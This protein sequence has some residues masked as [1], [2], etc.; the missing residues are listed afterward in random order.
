MWSQNFD[1]KKYTRKQDSLNKNDYEFLKQELEKTRYYSKC[2]HGTTYIPINRLND[3]FDI[4]NHTNEDSYFV[5]HS[6]SQYSPPVV[7]FPYDISIDNS[8][9]ESYKKY[10]AEYGHTL[11]NLFTPDKIINESV[12]N[13]VYVDLATTDVIPGGIT[14][15]KINLIID[16]IKAKEGHRILVKSQKTYITLNNSIDPETYFNG[17]YYINKSDVLNT[18]YY[19]YNSENGIYIFLNKRLIRETDLNNYEDCI[20]Y[21]IGCKLGIANADKQYHLARLANG[22]YPLYN[23]NDN[24]EFIEKHNWLLRNR[25]DYNNVLDIDYNDILKLPAHTIMILGYTYSIPERTIAIGEFG[26]IINTQGG[27]PNIINN[28]HKVKLNSITSTSN[29]YWICGD[30]GTMLK[31]EKLSFNIE[32][33]ELNTYNNLNSVSFFNN[34]RGFV[35]GDF[36]TLYETIDG[37]IS[38]KAIEVEE[39]INF[40]YNKVLYYKFNKVYVGGDNG[41]FLELEYLNSEWSIYKRTIRKI[42]DDDDDFELIFDINDITTISTNSWNIAYTGTSST[43]S[44]NKEALLI[45]T[46]NDNIIIHDINNFSIHDFIYL[47]YIQPVG[48]IKSII[49]TGTSSNQ[50]YFNSEN[51]IYTFDINEF[52]FVD[53]VS[54]ISKIGITNGTP[55]YNTVFTPAI[56][57]TNKIYNYSNI[58][59]EITGNKSLLLSSTYSTAIT[60]PI[61]TTSFSDSLKSKLLFLDYEI[62]S[63]L[64]FFDDQQNYRLPNTL[65]LSFVD[66]IT[67]TNVTSIEI[68]NQPNEYNWLSYQKDALKTIRYHSV[69]AVSQVNQSSI[70]E[71]STKFRISSISNSISLT[72][73]SLT[74][75]KDIVKHLAPTIDTYGISNF[76]NTGNTLNVVGIPYTIYAYNDIIIISSNNIIALEGD[77]LMIESDVIKSFFIINRVEVISGKNYYYCYSKYD[78]AILNDLKDSSGPIIITNLNTFN[79][80]QTFIDRFNEHPISVGYSVDIDNGKTILST[81]FNNFTAYYNMSSDVEINSVI[82]PMNYEK[83]FLDFGFKPTYNLLGYLSHIDP[84]VFSSSKEFKVMP[85]YYG[86]PFSNTQPTFNG[87]YFDTN[88]GTNKLFFSLS[89]KTE[90]DLLFDNTFID[91]NLNYSSSVVSTEKLLITKKYYDK[92]N[93]WYVIEFH[94]KLK[95]NVGTT[96]ASFDVISR[97]RL[98]QISQDLEELNNIQRG[99]SQTDYNIKFGQNDTSNIPNVWSFSNLEG[100]LNSK[101]NTNSYALIFTADHDIKELITGIVYIDSKNQLALNTIKLSREVNSDIVELMMHTNN[102][103][104]LIRTATEHKLNV[105]DGFVL[106][107]KDITNTSYY[108]NPQYNGYLTVN[109]WISDTIFVANI[110]FGSFTIGDVGS[111][112]HV[113][114]DPFFNYQPVDIIDVGIDKKS[115][116]SV[117]ILPK[118]IKLEGSKYNLINLDLNKFKF[119]LVD[120]LNLDLITKNYSWLLEAEIDNAIIGEDENGLVWY[121]GIWYCGRWFGGTWYSGEW[122]SGDWYGGIWDSTKVENKILSVNVD[123]IIKDNSYSVWKSGKW[124]DGEWR[125]G[126]W[127]NGAFYGGTWENGDWY[128][129]VWN[130][131]T[132]NNGKFYGGVWVDGLWNNGIFSSRFRPA[133]WLNGKWYGGDFENG[134]WFNGNWAQHEGKL[135]RFGTSPSNSRPAIWH[136]GKWFAGQFHSILNIDSSG[137]A[138]VSKRHSYSYWNT[139]IWMGGDFYGGVAHN[140]DMRN[141]R[142]M[143]GISEELNIRGVISSTNNNAIELIGEWRF[144]ALDNIYVIDNNIHNTLNTLGSNTEPSVY[145]VKSINIDYS[146]PGKKTTVYIYYKDNTVPLPIS[147]IAYSTTALTGYR[148]VSHFSRSKWYSGIWENGIFSEGEFYGGVWYNGLFE[149]SKWLT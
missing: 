130:D 126:T 62:A 78:N 19:F 94:K 45:V 138:Q 101:F 147:S 135:S 6:T 111:I 22:F 11:K 131:G 18:E 75:D 67:N 89:I 10:K 115:K 39:F 100:E 109:E 17:N 79:N 145:Q 125:L 2:L 87:I 53:L 128:N 146:I 127:Y 118:N 77:V 74:I 54:N 27:V 83:S 35:V 61:L 38:W 123:N 30:E 4:L 110:P 3:V 65:D 24:I 40:K 104:L 16:G 55:N 90:W 13:F 8:T 84:I 12:N 140:I 98:D 7:A 124:Y 116:R 143:G 71:F 37:G 103:Y 141:G 139:G 86:I 51:D 95:Y 34:L 1:T 60:Q 49:V 102:N 58:S 137:V 106:S 133:Y 36:N 26:V 96:I 25:V 121:T 70:V 48:D 5:G 57:N 33:I 59:L 42:V 142:W 105:N 43:M 134:F 92:T 29:Y 120:G 23:N 63:K 46:D 69:A 97:N 15:E 56:P 80:Q 119:N 114:G 108:V 144:N 31:V 91:I 64:N 99:K 129:G 50:V 76:V 136:G 14:G 148:V 149:N 21:S 32:K 66:F 81:I 107:L 93:D 44:G 68:T 20:R 73:S 41:V 72:A 113:K 132:W 122:V 88:V 9:I 52:K 85:K 28:K 82:Y 47:D 117:T 112:S